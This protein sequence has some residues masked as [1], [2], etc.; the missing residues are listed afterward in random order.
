MSIPFQTILVTTD[1]SPLGD[2]AIPYAV[3]LA[4]DHGAKLVVATVVEIPPSP[5]PLYAH[6]YPSPTSAQRET[7]RRAAAKGLTECLASQDAPGIRIERAILEGDPASEIVALAQ[8]LAASLL[9][10]ST[11]GRTGLNSSSS[12][13][14]PS[15]SCG[16]PPAPCSSSDSTRDVRPVAS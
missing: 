5:N 14:S 13:A 12:A 4:K 11:H 1:L 15:G 7:A 6:Y 2:A 9:V 10:I 3:R 16:A 8:S